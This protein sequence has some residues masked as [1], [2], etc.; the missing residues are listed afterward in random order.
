MLAVGSGDGHL[1]DLPPA[2]HYAGLGAGASQRGSGL[3]A[4]LPP[5][6]AHLVERLAHD[7]FVNAYAAVMRQS[8]AVTV[9]AA[10]LF[11]ALTCALIVRRP[12][13]AASA[14]RT[15]LDPIPD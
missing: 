7:V 14:D 12:V 10:F 13:G 15:A 2:C 9:A 1:P 3:P 8:L 4:G 11:A 6:V 5:G